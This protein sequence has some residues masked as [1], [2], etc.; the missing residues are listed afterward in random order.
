MAKPKYTKPAS[1]LHAEEVTKSGYDP[2]RLDK[3]GYPDP[4]ENG[5]V[6]VDPIYQNF[7]NETEKPYVAEGGAEKKVEAPFLADEVDLDAGATP[8]GQ[9]EAEEQVEEEEEQEEPLNPGGSTSSSGGTPT[10][11]ST[12]STPP[13]S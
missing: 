13:S 6:G 8:K 5:Y 3:G 12:P 7:A 1:T 10:S 11:P 2:G 9:S 4:S